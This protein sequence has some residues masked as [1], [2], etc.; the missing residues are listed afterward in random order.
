MPTKSILHKSET[1]PKFLPS[2]H[3]NVLSRPRTRH[4]RHYTQCWGDTTQR[5]CTEKLTAWEDGSVNMSR[6][7]A[8]IQD[9]QSAEGAHRGKQ[10]AS[11][12]QKEKQPI[13]LQGTIDHQLLTSFTLNIFNMAEK[14]ASSFEMFPH[15]GERKGT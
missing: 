13:L 4:Y 9:R 15:S 1:L 12:H 8:I 14:N 5:P 10:T 7:R 3:E 11:F 6:V 2:L